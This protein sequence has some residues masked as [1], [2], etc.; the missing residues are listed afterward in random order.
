MKKIIFNSL[1]VAFCLAILGSCNKDE[2]SIEKNESTAWEID[3]KIVDDDIRTRIG[4]DPR[5]D[6][7]TPTT[8]EVVAP[9][10]TLEGFTFADKN[11]RTLEVKLTKA[12]DKDVTVS[13]MYDASLFSKIAGNYSGYELGDASLAEI[14]TTQKTIAAGT[15]TTTFEIKVTNQSTFNKKVI[16]PFAVKASNNEF[17]KTLSGKDYFVVRIYPKALTFDTTNKKII[18]EAVLKAGKAELTNKVVNIAITS[19][20]AI[21]T[22]ISLGLERDNS[23]LT[24]GTLA[25]ENIVGTISKVDF[26]DKTSATISFTLQNIESISAKGTYVVPFKLMAYDASGMGHKVL[27][28]PILL[29]IEVGDEGIP[30]D[31]EVEVSTDYSVTMMNSSKYSFETNYMPGHVEKMH[32]G[33]LYGNPWW[34]DTSIDEDSDDSPYV[35]VHFTSKTL[36]NGIRITQNTSE[37]RIG[38]VFIYAVTDEGSY[39]HQGTYDASGSQKPRFLYIKFKK[40]IKASKLYLAY[41]RNSDNQYIDINEMQFF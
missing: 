7:V 19:S 12:S 20:D 15:T 25:P 1:T 13:L 16:L 23:L 8:S 40:P 38:Q 34:I 21:G 37:K 3:K 35:Y 6:Y 14:A 26:K 2:I 36:I 41:F 17:V 39:I 28:T 10:L 9:M 18:K 24:S 32:D 4:Y 27:D 11:T 30:T 29:N 5:F 31:N 22:P 33:N